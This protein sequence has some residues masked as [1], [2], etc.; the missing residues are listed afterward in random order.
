MLDPDLA[1]L[2]SPNRLPSSKTHIK[3]L[4]IVY[5]PVI[6]LTQPSPVS[7]HLPPSPS[8]SSPGLTPSHSSQTF[9]PGGGSSPGSLKSAA[10]TL[11]PKHQ[12]SLPRLRPPTWHS[13]AAASATTAKAMAPGSPEDEGDGTSTGISPV[14]TSTDF[15]RT[16]THTTASSQQ[17]HRT[18]PYLSSPLRLVQ[19]LRIPAQQPFRFL[20]RLYLLGVASRPINL[21]SS[22]L[23]RLD[24]RQQG[25]QLFYW[26]PIL[27][28][29]K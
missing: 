14:I 11:P 18:R 23:P 26:Q 27:L 29:S 24:S 4:S 9:M 20:P 7:A 17:Q 8:G 21:V 13:P 3:C 1:S 6:D 28:S 16:Q 5:P 15:S 22:A 19:A 2:L 25:E 10:R 12:S